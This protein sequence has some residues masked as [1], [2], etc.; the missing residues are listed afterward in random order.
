MYI[1][2]LYHYLQL[3]AVLPPGSFMVRPHETSPQQLFLSFRTAAPAAPSNSFPAAGN[4][5]SAA[6]TPTSSAGPPT[7]LGEVKHAIIRRE[8]SE[9][10][11]NDLAG[12]T[13]EAGGNDLA[14][15][16]SGRQQE[17]FTYQCGKLGPAPSLIDILR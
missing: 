6:T 9:A 17:G 2:F 13:S 11:G 1:H 4:A 14:G 3:L 16:T 15:G 8:T 7:E 12:G 10:G 5:G